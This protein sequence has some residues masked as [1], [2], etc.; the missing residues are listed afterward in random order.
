MESSISA[1]SLITTQNATAIGQ[2]FLFVDAI[3]ICEV[4]NPSVVGLLTLWL[5]THYVFNIVY[6]KENNN[7]AMVLEDCVLMEKG[8]NSLQTLQ[9]GAS[10]SKTRKVARSTKLQTLYG[11]L[12]ASGLNLNHI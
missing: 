3:Q 12:K 4:T 10:C 11:R 1:P 7:V 2:A 6:G 8:L 9:N 5:A